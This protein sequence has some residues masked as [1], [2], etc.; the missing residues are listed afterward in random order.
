MGT[1]STVARLLDM[2][3]ITKEAMVSVTRWSHVS[4]HD[5][6]IFSGLIIKLCRLPYALEKSGSETICHTLELLQTR[7][8]DLSW[9]ANR[10]Q[11]CW[12][13]ARF[14]SPVGT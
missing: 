14:G 9:C 6:L 1:K 7:D 8:S 10:L 2:I 13:G 5:L 4:P 11:R 3:Q 12:N